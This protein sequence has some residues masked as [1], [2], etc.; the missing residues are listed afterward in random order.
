MSELVRERKVRFLGICEVGE[1]TIRRA[2]AVHPLAALQIEYSLWTRDVEC[3]I[4]PLC[5]ALGIGFVAYRR[6]KRRALRSSAAA[7]HSSTTP[8]WPRIKL[9]TTADMD[10]RIRAAGVPEPAKFS[11][12]VKGADLHVRKP[13]AIFGK[14]SGRK[15][16]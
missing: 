4:L 8:P 9:R 13:R 11:K 12:M 10:G 6:I 1:A 14:I 16:G 7:R 2:H 3:E 15:R 5:E